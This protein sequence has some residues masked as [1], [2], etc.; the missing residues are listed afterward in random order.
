NWSLSVAKEVTLIFGDGLRKAC[1]V[2][3]QKRRLIG[4]AF[5]DGVASLDQQALMMTEKEQ[6]LHR[7]Q[8]GAQIRSVREARGYTEVQ[9][10]S[11]LGVS[12][13]FVSLAESGEMNIA[14]HELTRFDDML[15]VYLV[16]LVARPVMIGSSPTWTRV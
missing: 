13:E 10:A 15:L 12:R 14:L 4:V 9:I 3:W 2:A 11:L 6:I 5:A 8:I 16:R 1:R 7:K